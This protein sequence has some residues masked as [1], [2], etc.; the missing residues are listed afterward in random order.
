MGKVGKFN[1]NITIVENDLSVD[2]SIGMVFMALF[3]SVLLITLTLFF[4]IFV[5]WKYGIN[6]TKSLKPRLV[7][8]RRTGNSGFRYS[9]PCSYSTKVNQFSEVLSNIDRSKNNNNKK[10]TTEHGV[11]KSNSTAP[12]VISNTLQKKLLCDLKDFQQIKDN[13][14]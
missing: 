7:T 12:K 5:V 9:T 4:I 10:S 3:A 13:N 6:H 11:T 1:S 8:T 14:K 2:T